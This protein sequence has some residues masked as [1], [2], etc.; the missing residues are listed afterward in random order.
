MVKGFVI[1][2]EYDLRYYRGLLWMVVMVN[3]V[4]IIVIVYYLYGVM[5]KVRE[6][7]FFKIKFIYLLVDSNS[8][9]L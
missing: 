7:V 1:L 4:K 5:K 6:I 8:F 3:V 9:L 2:E